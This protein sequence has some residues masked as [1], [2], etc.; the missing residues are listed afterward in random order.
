[1]GLIIMKVKMQ[2]QVV[3]TNPN[4][5]L[6]GLANLGLR[7][8]G[9]ISAIVLTASH[10]PYD[11]HLELSDA[12]ALLGD[13][14]SLVIVGARLAV[15][16]PIMCNDLDNSNATNLATITCSRDSFLRLQ[17]LYVT[18]LLD[19][20]LQPPDR[21]LSVPNVLRT[22]IYHVFRDSRGVSRGL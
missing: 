1:M 9:E 6:S 15:S 17:C 2:L 10:S 7:A 20:L 19:G 18:R 12:I 13:G 16:E 5:F 4:L 3:R 8:I 22:V 21:R 14:L 11:S